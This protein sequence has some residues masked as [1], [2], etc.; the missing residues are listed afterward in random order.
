MKKAP[1]LFAD[2]P[3]TDLV[4]D[5]RLASK[6]ALTGRKSSASEGRF[7]EGVRPR[8]CRLEWQLADHHRS[9]N[10]ATGT[11]TDTTI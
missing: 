5:L 10:I 6:V 7:P 11:E 3:R 9:R 1:R 8:I 2:R 4:V